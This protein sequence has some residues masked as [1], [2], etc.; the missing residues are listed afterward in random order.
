MLCNPPCAHSWKAASVLRGS[1]GPREEEQRSESWP[2]AQLVDSA[3]L[4]VMELCP[5]L[6]LA[7]PVR[8]AW[9]RGA[10]PTEPFPNHTLVNKTNNCFK[11]QS[12]GV[13]CYLAI[14]NGWPNKMVFALWR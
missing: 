6:N 5:A 8:F 4:P 1:P 3:N 7:T 2:R 12:F 10:A 13:I 9:D 11:P 14:D